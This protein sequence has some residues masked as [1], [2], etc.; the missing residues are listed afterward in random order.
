M[1]AKDILEWIVRDE[2][3]GKFLHT[4]VVPEEGD[5]EWEQ[6]EE[7]WWD[8]LGFV[9]P[10]PIEPGK[11]LYFYV[12]EVANDIW[13]SNG[14]YCEPDAEIEAYNDYIHLYRLED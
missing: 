8:T 11:Y 7:W 2:V 3:E 9:P 14:G 5:E 10:C 13:D 4:I 1:K 6:N 12:S